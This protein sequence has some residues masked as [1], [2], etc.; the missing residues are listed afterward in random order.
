MEFN[1]DD[2]SSPLVSVGIPTYNRLQGLKRTLECITSQT[3]Q[4]LEI[5]V[6]DNASYDPEISI[7]MNE[8]MKN[9]KRI[10]YFRQHENIGAYNNFKFVLNKSSGEY[11]MWAADDDEWSPDFIADCL[12]IMQ[13]KKVDTVMCQFAVHNRIKN[14]V[15]EQ[16]VPRLT[17]EKSLFSNLKM[18]ISNMTPSIVY[19]LHRRKTLDFF[20]GI[21]SAFDYLDCVFVIRQ[22]CCTNGVFVTDK[23]LYV[24]GIDTQDY[25]VKPANV[26]KGKVLEYKPFIKNVV[27]LIVTSNKL[28]MVEKCSL[29]KLFLSLI[30]TLFITFEKKVRPIQTKI[31]SLIFKFIF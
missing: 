15:E 23:Y 8:Y 6:S 27:K 12:C 14:T 19:G 26:R 24:A 25:S 11:F 9:D 20:Q 7:I 21:S 31:A 29:L 17:P 16:Q 1:C 2:L 13:N 5:I 28:N 22:I 3:Y 30:L 10:R 4:N 18:F